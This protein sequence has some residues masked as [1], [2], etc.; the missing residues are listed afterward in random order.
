M[1]LLEGFESALLPCSLILLVP[2]LAA[3]IAARQESTPALLGFAGGATI[4]AW[5]RFSATVGE[6][7]RFFVAVAFALGALLL[8]VPLFR[9]LDVVTAGGGLLAGAAAA[10]LW[11]PCVGEEFGMLLGDLPGRG[12]V[13]GA[14]FVAYMVGVFAPL[15]IVGAVMALIPDTATLPV[16][17]PMM[18]LGGGALFVLAAATAVGLDDDLVSQ[19]VQWSI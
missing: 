18:V 14:M 12:I 7:I 3:A 9:R 5:L 10:A 4:A 6:P 19:L 13:D 8:L 2:G 1:I 17:V 15:V 11:Q 16:R